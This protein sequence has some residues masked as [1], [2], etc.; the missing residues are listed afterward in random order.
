MTVSFK[1]TGWYWGFEYFKVT[2]ESEVK[3][4]KSNT[5]SDSYNNF[6]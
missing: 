5:H 3:G 2:V 1:D 6:K 4:K